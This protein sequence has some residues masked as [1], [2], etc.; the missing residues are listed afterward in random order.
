MLELI[1]LMTAQYCSANGIEA[2]TDSRLSGDS[3]ILPASQV[4]VEAVP[5]AYPKSSPQV[6]DLANGA[7]QDQRNSLAASAGSDIVNPSD[8]TS[9][10]VNVVLAPSSDVTTPPGT[11]TAQS[12]H[13]N[14]PRLPQAHPDEGDTSARGKSHPSPKLVPSDP[15]SIPSPFDSVSQLATS[16]RRYHPEPGA[17]GSSDLDALNASTPPPAFGSAFASD[18][19]FDHTSFNGGL[20]DIFEPHPTVSPRERPLT[21][22]L[23]D[24]EG[25]DFCPRQANAYVSE[26][27]EEGSNTEADETVESPDAV[28]PSSPRSHHMNRD[29]L[30]SQRRQSTGS[31]DDDHDSDFAPM[32][33]GQENASYVSGPTTSQLSATRGSRKTRRADRRHRPKGDSASSP[34]S[35]SFPLPDGAPAKKRNASFSVSENS[36]DY[37]RSKP[38]ALVL[39][40]EQKRIA[41]DVDTE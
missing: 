11:Q 20:G 26:S 40:E 39:T 3:Q 9:N 19:N 22:H 2:K 1:D 31:G 21:L 24:D 36:R 34:M 29:R 17:I 8:P 37:K 18:P 38:P 41:I 12:N 10:T 30:S 5:G 25:P 13:V 35:T 32:E 4:S 7:T 16:H 14:T 28:G 15:A 27:I 6:G 23:R 33:A